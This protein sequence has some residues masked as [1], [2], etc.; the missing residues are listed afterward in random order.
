M[1]SLFSDGNWEEIIQPELVWVT[2]VGLWQ[3]Q[4]QAG[5]NGGNYPTVGANYVSVGD[6]IQ[7]TIMQTT[8]GESYGQGWQIITEDLNTGDT[9]SLFYETGTGWPNFNWAIMGAYE[10]QGFVGCGGLSE[11]DSIQFNL[12]HIREGGPDWNSYVN[13]DVTWSATTNSVTDPDCDYGAVY[14]SGGPDTVLSWEY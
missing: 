4:S 3:I 1:E 11:S 7:G 10:P 13:A 5:Q 9:E 8:N 12:L 6:V 14:N 2:S